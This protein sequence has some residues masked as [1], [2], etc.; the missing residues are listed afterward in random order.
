MSELSSMDKFIIQDDANNEDLREIIIDNLNYE[1]RSTFHMKLSKNYLE[2]FAKHKDIKVEWKV[3]DINNYLKED[4]YLRFSRGTHLPIFP[5]NS[6]CE[7]YHTIEVLSYRTPSLLKKE[8]NSEIIAVIKINMSASEFKNFIHSTR[9]DLEYD[10]DLKKLFK[11]A[12]LN[13]E[14]R[15]F[16]IY[17]FKIS[18]RILDLE[19]N[20]LTNFKSFHVTI[21]PTNLDTYFDRPSIHKDYDRTEYLTLKDGELI[22]KE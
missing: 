3:D 11:F 18:P 13:Y 20:N 14:Y 2:K 10:I 19:E 12:V 5:N 4:L 22:D 16:M 1:S 9:L 8:Q 6:D 7:I 15:G 17:E 21:T